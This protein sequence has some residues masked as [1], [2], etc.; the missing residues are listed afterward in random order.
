MF[1]YV[2]FFFFLLGCVGAFDFTPLFLME[3]GNTM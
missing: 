1:F 3:E 2:F